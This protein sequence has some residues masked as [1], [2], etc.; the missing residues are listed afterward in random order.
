MSGI[1]CDRNL[2]KDATQVEDWRAR[3]LILNIADIVR[4]EVRS[5]DSRKWCTYGAWPAVVQTNNVPEGMCL[6]AHDPRTQEAWVVAGPQCHI[7]DLLNLENAPHLYSEDR[8][9]EYYFVPA[10]RVPAG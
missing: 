5:S 10:D 7:G 1:Q 2:L 9:F 6:V 8:G 3:S 4:R